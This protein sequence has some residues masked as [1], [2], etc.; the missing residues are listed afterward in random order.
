MRASKRLPQLVDE[1][2]RDGREIVDE[3]ERVLDLVRDAGGQLAE[4]GQLLGLDKAVLRGS[5]I[6]QRRFHIVE[7]AR[8]LD[9]Q[10]RLRR[11]SLHQVDGILRKGARRAAADHQHADDLLP[12]QQRRHQPRAETSAQDDLVRG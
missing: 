9:R 5:Q 12:T 6:L 4:R 11:E 1:L 7:Q 8:I 10:R 3:I 2:D